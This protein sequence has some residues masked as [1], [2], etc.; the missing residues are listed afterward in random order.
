[1][2][3]LKFQWFQLLRKP[4]YS[5][6]N[7]SLTNEYPNIFVTA[8]Y[9]QMNIPIYSVVYIFTNLCLN[10][11]DHLEY[12]WM[13]IQIYSNKKYWPN[14]MA[15]EYKWIVTMRKGMRTRVILLISIAEMS[16]CIIFLKQLIF[17]WASFNFICCNLTFRMNIQIYSWEEKSLK[18]MSEYFCYG[19]IHEYL[20]EWIYLSINI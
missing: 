13:N 19:K 3:S 2:D 18:L 7:F 10:I 20:V 17:C 16:N 11:F 14:I 1:M 15:N 6:C 4:V 12:S 8:N 9:S 5:K